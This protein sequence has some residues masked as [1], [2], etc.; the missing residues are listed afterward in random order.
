M[1]LIKGTGRGKCTCGTPTEIEMQNIRDASEEAV[2]EAREALRIAGDAKDIADNA[3]NTADD[4][5]N[6]ADGAQD[7]LDDIMDGTVTVP[8]AGD[9]AYATNA[10]YAVHATDAGYA[11]TAGS[12]S[13]A[14]NLPYSAKR[15]TGT[16]NDF[17]VFRYGKI[18]FVTING[19]SLTKGVTATFGVGEFPHPLYDGTIGGYADNETRVF[20]TSGTNQPIQVWINSN[21]NSLEMYYANGPNT[22][23]NISGWLIYLSNDPVV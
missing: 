4:A 3:Q 9:A 8:K 15:I 19:I 20:G 22:E 6:T 13:I 14:T 2:R 1:V 12:A 23:A 7:A 21:N 17:Y 11:T 18:V 16:P 10:T 5:Q